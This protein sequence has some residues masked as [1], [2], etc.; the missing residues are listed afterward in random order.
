LLSEFNV[1]R[2]FF[3]LGDVYL[4]CFCVNYEFVLEKNHIKSNQLF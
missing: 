2:G 3:L 1:S 4:R